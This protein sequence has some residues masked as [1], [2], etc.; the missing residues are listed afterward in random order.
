MNRQGRRGYVAI[1]FALSVLL[2][3]A[4]LLWVLTLTVTC[5]GLACERGEKSTQALYAAEA[6]LDVALQA[7]TQGLNGG[8]IGT[9]RNV[10]RLSGDLVISVGETPRAFGAPARAAVM[11]R[12]GPSGVAPGSWRQVPPLQYAS[13]FEWKKP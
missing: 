7:R 13:L 3:I 4:L 12:V 11:A 1:T 5:S 2:L 10:T 9:S 6:G 8:Q